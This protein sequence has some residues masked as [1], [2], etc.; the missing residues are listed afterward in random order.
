MLG[1]VIGGL[2]GNEFGPRAPFIAAGVISLL[3]VIYGY[4]FL[5]ETLAKEKRR[6]FSWA[7]SNPFGSLKS[8]GR[9]RGVKGLIFIFFLMATA[10]TV[11]PTTYTFSTQEGLG[12]TARC[13]P[14]FGR[15]RDCQHDRARRSHSGHNPKDR[16]FL[17]RYDWNIIR[18]DCLYNDG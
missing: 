15:F 2:F 8:L 7:R 9:I 10:H 3:N 18:N 4:I 12:W 11:Y 13:R 14:V 1:P 5:P 16:S 17:G 6:P